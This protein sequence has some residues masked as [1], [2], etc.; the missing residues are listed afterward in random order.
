MSYGQGSTP[1]PDRAAVA[2]AGE[3][4][5]NAKRLRH[6]TISVDAW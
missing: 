1:G 5:P 3:R 4:S 2:L 6:L